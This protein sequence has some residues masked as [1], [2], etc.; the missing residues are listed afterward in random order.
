MTGATYYA[1]QVEENASGALMMTTY[2]LNDGGHTIVGA[3]NG[4]TIDSLGNDK[5]EGG[6]SGETLILNAVYGHD[7]I[8]DFV[9]YD[10]GS[11]HDTISLA[12]SELATFD[13]VM[14]A[15]VSSGGNTVITAADGDTLTLKG[16]PALT[17]AMSADFTFHA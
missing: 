11:N 10:T 3:Q 17:N 7:T 4:L 13:A 6:G 9:S 5:M 8:T 2:D 1:Y 16:L 15:A 14:N 12:R